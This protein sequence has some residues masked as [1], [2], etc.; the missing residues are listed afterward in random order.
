MERRKILSKRE[1]K[2]R[3]FEEK[4]TDLGTNVA[5]FR[6]FSSRRCWNW[7]RTAVAKKWFTAHISL[8]MTRGSLGP[9][10]IN[11]VH[12]LYILLI[13]YIYSAQMCANCKTQKLI[14]LNKINCNYVVSTGW[15]GPAL[16]VRFRIPCAS[17]L[18]M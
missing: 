8:Q 2:Q 5:P 15:V 9:I 11:A 17:R 1:N 10:N 7:K 4:N 3:K 6:N 18:K 13:F 14:L 16:I 12:V